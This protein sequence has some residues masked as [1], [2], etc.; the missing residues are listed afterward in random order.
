MIRA[1]VYDAVGTI[2]H[3]APSVQAVY[4]DVARR[5]GCAMDEAEI[6]R[7]FLSAFAEQDLLDCRSGWQTSEAREHDRWRAI[8]ATVFPDIADADA[9]F[10]TLF[11]AFASPDVWAFDPDWLPAAKA[12]HQRGLRQAVASNFDARLHA[13]IAAM[14]GANFM[15]RVVVSSEIGWR[16]PAAE[17]FTRLLD[18]LQLPPEEVV[19]VGDDRVND[20]DAARR[21]GIAAVLLDPRKEHLELGH[22]RIEGFAELPSLFVI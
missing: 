2:M 19:F 6:R 1:I 8:V 14:P 11:Q 22:N 5:F 21:L 18:L 9:C 20:F 12:M 13:L 3:V 15:E 4:A 10:H 16:K 17:F 7:R